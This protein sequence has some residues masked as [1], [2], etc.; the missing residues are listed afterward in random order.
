MPRAKVEP[1]KPCVPVVAPAPSLDPTTPAGAR[2]LFHFQGFPPRSLVFVKLP[3][4]QRS[5]E[6]E[7]AARNIGELADQAAIQV[8]FFDA[9]H[10]WEALE[11]DDTTLARLGL[12]R[13]Q[14]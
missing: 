13:T 5:P 1:T 6:M 8:L 2:S 12:Y 7:L 3:Y 14:R 10:S 9:E 11:V 4:I